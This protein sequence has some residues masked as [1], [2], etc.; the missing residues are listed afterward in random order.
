LQARRESLRRGQASIQ[1]QIERLTEAYL[2]GVVSLEE[3][4]RRRRELEQR[5]QALATQARQLEAQ[6]DRQA[7]IERL[8][9]SLDEFRQRVRTG[10]AQATW[11][12]KRQLI[13]WLVTRVIVTDGEVEI[14]YAIPTTPSGQADR[15]SQLRSD[16]RV[17]LSIQQPGEARRG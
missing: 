17:R 9:L 5:E 3:Y 4:R 15:F 2:A 12:Q 10:L 7:E 16:H 11:E 6:V 1:Q 14:R 13:E 8:G